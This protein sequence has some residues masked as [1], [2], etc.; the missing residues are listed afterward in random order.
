MQAWCKLGTSL[1]QAWRNG[2]Q[3]PLWRASPPFRG[4][5]SNGFVQFVD[6]GRELDP[7]TEL[8]ILPPERHVLLVELLFR[9]RRRSPSH[10]C[11]Y[12]PSRACNGWPVKL[13]VLAIQIEP[14]PGLKRENHQN[15]SSLLSVEWVESRPLP[16]AR[17]SEKSPVTFPSER[18]KNRNTLH[19]WDNHRGLRNPHRVRIGAPPGR[20]WQ[21]TVGAGTRPRTQRRVQ[22]SG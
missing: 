13:W 1:V 11:G 16:P 8:I 22:G 7:C 20:R 9:V 14:S 21:D 6:T 17:T 18:A 19:K 12:A 4:T 15:G 3:V 2:V 5:V 10:L